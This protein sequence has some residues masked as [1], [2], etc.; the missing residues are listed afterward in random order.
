MAERTTTTT[1]PIAPEPAAT[2]APPAAR[3]WLVPTVLG[4]QAAALALV[5]IG[6]FG[7]VAVGSTAL[8]VGV[9]ILFLVLA[10]GAAGIAISYS[11]GQPAART[12]AMVF[13]GFA[14]ALA[15]LWF[16]PIPTL[17]ATLVAAIVLAIAVVTRHVSRQMR[18]PVPSQ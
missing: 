7:G 10:A 3:S 13:E 16:A 4:V 11:E 14:I 5:A 15:L 18:R 1:E 9:G 6:A 12:A 2:H 17:V 8:R